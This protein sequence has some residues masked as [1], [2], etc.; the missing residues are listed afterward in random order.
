[1]Q[2]RLK[3]KN[4][5]LTVSA[6]LLVLAAVLSL[7]KIPIAE[8]VYAATQEN[9]YESLD[10]SV[11]FKVISS[12]DGG[13]NAEIEIYNPTSST[14]EDWGLELVTY[15]EIVTIWN[16]AIEK[17]EDGKY[18]ISNLDYNQDVKAGATVS[19]G[20]ISNSSFTGY[21]EIELLKK[22][23]ITVDSEKYEV[24]YTI[25]SDW[26]RGANA[27]IAISNL[28][29]EKIEEWKLTFEF[30]GSIVNIWNGNV[31][32]H[33]GNN[34]V[35]AG[36]EYNQ[37]INPGA[38]VRVGFTI[39][40]E[41]KSLN[42]DNVSLEKYDYIKCEQTDDEIIT[43]DKEI[44]LYSDT[45]EI[46]GD[47]EYRT[48][49]FY[50]YVPM[51][52]SKVTLYDVNNDK[53]IEMY[54][55]GQYS[56]CGDDI[57]G[58]MIY[59]VKTTVFGGTEKGMT[60][61]YQA[62][63]DDT[64][65]S[66][67]Y[68]IKSY[69]YFSDADMADVEY[70]ND[71][72]DSIL[73]KYSSEEG[74]TPYMTNGGD[75]AGEFE[76]KYTELYDAYK[77][78]K[79]KGTISDFKYEEIEK[80]F[81]VYYSSGYVEV[82]SLMGY[83]DFY[84][85]DNYDDFVFPE[86]V[87]SLDGYS[88]KIFNCFE[89]TPFRTDYYEKLVDNLEAMGVKVSYEDYVTI[90]GLKRDMKG[91]DFICLS[92][93]G[94]TTI[95]ERPGFCVKDEKLNIYKSQYNYAADI[96]A[97]RVVPYKTVD[98]AYYVITSDFI[99]KNYGEGKLNGSFVFSEACE[100]MGA[101][102]Y[103]YNPEFANAFVNDAGAECVVGFYNSV[104]AVY[105]RNFMMSFFYDLMMG[106]TSGTAFDNAKTKYGKTDY[107]YREPS[108]FEW[109]IKHDAFE[110]MGPSAIP[111]FTGDKTVT[112]IRSLNNGDFEE[113]V[114][115]Y[116][117]EP[118]FWECSGDVRSISAIG[119]IKAYQSR[120]VL[121]T[122]G[123]GSKSAIDLSGTQGSSIK[124]LFYNKDSNKI[125]FSY[126]FISEEPMEYIGSRYDDKFVVR[127][128]DENGSVLDSKTVESINVS[129]WYPIEAIDFDGGDS[130]VYHTMWKTGEIDISKYQDT[131][132]E[133]EFIV[134]DVGDSDVDSAVIIDNIKL[135]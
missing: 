57:A 134:C 45:D 34:Y 37:G 20:Y 5:K 26:G 87:T 108:F 18:L 42:I 62:I 99:K 101:S 51:D 35:I 67:K 77:K 59:S 64:L 2:K 89:D 128:K 53:Y 12:W 66:E 50:A 125:E 70:V 9:N 33:E 17:N 40:S 41:N 71:I 27:E 23:Y 15:D 131:A 102:C 76:E 31:M 104:N 68:I 100:F 80:Q 25:V 85:G 60:Y 81:V 10:M 119:N 46:E 86:M 22:D 56:S 47:E 84:E 49:C 69:S 91:Y 130:T 58:D 19:F 78:L 129:N 118:C 83:S 120:M 24:E 124:Q 48:V 90:P 72:I 106:E 21:P 95:D 44:V 52:A 6:M 98:D 79:E 38:T 94:A 135:D 103:N 39:E 61:E 1:M 7:F 127:I 133:V 114:S 116:E 111:Y 115:Y 43:E 121:L 113:I 32:S 55:N 54:D 117:T 97:G 63:I 123:V 132:I 112:A 36:N 88:I 105:S 75:Y 29:E 30:A 13:Y 4:V 11:Q 109:L 110:K 65:K 126:D 92:G 28:S 8:S 96:K 14:Y 122:T 73:V 74:S 93:H 3:D 82:V 16:A 107:D